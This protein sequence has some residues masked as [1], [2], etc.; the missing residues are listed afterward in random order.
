MRGLKTAVENEERR[1]EEVEQKKKT[2]AS[3]GFT[4]DP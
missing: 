2:I 4:R 3:N 1:S